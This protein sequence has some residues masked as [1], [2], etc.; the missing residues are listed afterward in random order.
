M[1][2]E[3]LQF[4]PP[5]LKRARVRRLPNTIEVLSSVQSAVRLRLKPNAS[6]LDFLRAVYQCKRLPMELRIEAATAAL[7]FIH[8][9]LIAV[10]NG[11]A[12]PQQIMISGGLPRLPGCST[13]M[14]FEPPPMLRQ[15]APEQ[16]VTPAEPIG[17]PEVSGETVG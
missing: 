13:V 7:P 3:P 16:P 4:N 11:S 2:G 14:P 12:G 10:V 6:P 9:R 17:T 8:P 5:P 1:I 15:D